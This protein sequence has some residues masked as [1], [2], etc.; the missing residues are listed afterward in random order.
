M[1]DENDLDVESRPASVKV[2]RLHELNLKQ[3]KQILCENRFPFFIFQLRASI[4]KKEIII[5]LHHC[6]TM[7]GILNTPLIWRI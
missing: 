6:N 5:I 2:C 3:A 7:V 1:L 4:K